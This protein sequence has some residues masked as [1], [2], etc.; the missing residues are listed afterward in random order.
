MTADAFKDYQRQLKLVDEERGAMGRRALTS[1]K[2][3]DP[4]SY[5]YAVDVFSSESKA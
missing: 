1:L 5:E 3:S 4:E 2:H